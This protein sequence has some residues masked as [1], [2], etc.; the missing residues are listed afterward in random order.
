MAFFKANGVIKQDFSGFKQEI[1]RIFNENKEVIAQNNKE[2]LKFPNSINQAIE[3]KVENSINSENS[4]NNRSAG[5]LNSPESLKNANL[6]ASDASLAPGKKEDLEYSETWDSLM[7]KRDYC[8]NLLEKTEF[9]REEIA[10]LQK[11][12]DKNIEIG[13]KVEYMEAMQQGLELMKKE[14]QKKLEEL[15]QIRNEI[16][17]KAKDKDAPNLSKLIR[18]YENMKP[19]D[20]AKI[21]NLLDNDVLIDIAENM[22]ESKFAAIL[23]RMDLKKVEEFNKIVNYRR[24]ILSE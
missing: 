6:T 21:F 11:L 22:K 10:V 15:S 9:N 20:C 14:I 18:I 3:K 16:M 19:E 17:L 12:R 5:L 7:S 23:A 13:Q 24:I 4:Q 2:D 8:I 1:L